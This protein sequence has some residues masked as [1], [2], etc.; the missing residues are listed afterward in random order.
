VETSGLKILQNVTTRW[1]SLLEPLKHALGEYK[2]LIVKMTWDAAKESKAAHNLR[3]LCNVHILL[4]LP[5]LMPFF[6]SLN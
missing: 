4:A 5:C 2:M 6:E 3:V 1:I